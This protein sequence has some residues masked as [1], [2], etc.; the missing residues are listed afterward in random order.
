[1]K[2]MKK[3]LIALTVA[4]T[5]LIASNAHAA[6][7]LDPARVRFGINFGIGSGI[8][9]AADAS[10]NN[11]AT[12]AP[13]VN[14]G[15]RISAGYVSPAFSV[16]AAPVATFRFDNGGVWVGPSV[17]LSIANGGSFGFGVTTGVEYDVSQQ[18]MVYGGLYLG[19][20]PS[21]AGIINAGVDI[22]LLQNI[23]G[24]FEARTNFGAGTSF[25]FGA[26]LAYR[27]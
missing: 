22:E 11:L 27:F 4:A 14:L 10:L 2:N 9:F 6:D 7:A 19:V 3:S 13:G 24:F 5:G 21:V 1:M 8:G 20:I 23:S 25:G 17:N 26:G 12:I 15:A 16:S 18:I